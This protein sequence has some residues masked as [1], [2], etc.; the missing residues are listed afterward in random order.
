MPLGLVCL[1]QSIDQRFLTVDQPFVSI[2]Q[3]FVSINQRYFLDRS[4][5]FSRGQN[6]P[7]RRSKQSS[8]PRSKIDHPT[9]R[10]FHSR[11]TS[12]AVTFCIM[13]HIINQQ[14]SASRSLMHPPQRGMSAHR[15][16]PPSQ[17]ASQQM[18]PP[19]RPASQQAAP[20]LAPILPPH[21]QVPQ[22]NRPIAPVSVT[23]PVYPLD[24]FRANITM[25]LG[26]YNIHQANVHAEPNNSRD[27]SN[28]HAQADTYSNRGIGHTDHRANPHN[29]ADTYSDH[30]IDD[31]GNVVPIIGPNGHHFNYPP[32]DDNRDSPP[33]LPTTP[34]LPPAHQEPYYSGSSAGP[35]EYPLVPTVLT[36]IDHNSL[37]AIFALP[38]EK[39]EVAKRILAMTE[40]NIMGAI[41]YGLVANQPARPNAPNL[42]GNLEIPTD[43]V[44]VSPPAAV[45][46]PPPDIRH[47][48]YSDYIKMLESR[49]IAYS[50]HHDDDGATEIQSLFHTTQ[51]HVASLPHHIQSQHLPTGF[52]DGNSH[53]R[54]SVLALVRGLLKHDWVLL[55]NF[56]RSGGVPSLEAMYTSI[57]NVFLES[58]GAHAPRVNWANIPM[59]IKVRFAYLRLE[60]AAH[61]MRPSPGHGSQWTP[62]DALLAHLQTKSM[63]F[64]KAWADLIIQLDERLFGIGGVVFD[65]VRD[66]VVLP[67]DQDVEDSMQATRVLPTLARRPLPVM[68]ENH[69]DMED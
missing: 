60:T 59:R 54:R 48:L 50:R 38:E 53:A 21:L 29:Q 64:V 16:P 58:S 63:D 65:T 22:N 13:S 43:L 30:G 20:V 28:P 47:F 23:A 26:G 57:H 45:E 66:L 10:S 34:L 36:N 41:V 24:P 17:S 11:P 37:Q 25:G 2:N 46:N 49:I 51:E 40:A 15:M 3:P 62:I 9:S 33:S 42:D 1:G 61:T 5:V 12:G 67:T 14:H 8:E 27:R 35:R 39:I 32:A 52:V 69:F 31:A 6:D 56:V 55:R 44:A 18:P 7:S 4:T 19:S 68:E